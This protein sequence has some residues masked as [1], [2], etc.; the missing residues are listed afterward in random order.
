MKNRRVLMLMKKNNLEV[1][2]IECGRILEK[3]FPRLLQNKLKK[4]LGEIIF[5]GN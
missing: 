3:Y 1:K 4:Y 5:Q 2:R